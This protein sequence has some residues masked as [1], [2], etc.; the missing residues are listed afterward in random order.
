MIE[1]LE[2]F[3]QKRSC[4]RLQTQSGPPSNDCGH[5]DGRVEVSCE[6]VVAGC[7]A[8]PV[9]E[10]AE[11]PFDQVAAL[12]GFAI[13][14]VQTLARRIV[15]NDRQR[16]AL[17]HELPQS[18]AVVGRIGRTFPARWQLAEE[19]DGG[20]DVAQLSRRHFDGDG[21]S[22]RIADR[23]DLGRAPSTRAT[24]SLRFGPPFPPAAERCAFAVVESIV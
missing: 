1:A 12:V 3:D 19:A 2:R 4:S 15:R 23:V 13:E 18:V 8:A 20:A 21:A 16:S 10:A 7:N 22:E 14:G 5:G 24:D 17:T 9:F 6:L 11:G